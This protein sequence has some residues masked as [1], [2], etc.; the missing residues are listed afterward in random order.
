MDAMLRFPFGSAVKTSEDKATAPR[1]A[2]RQVESMAERLFTL[3]YKVCILADN[4]ELLAKALGKKGVGECRGGGERRRS[5]RCARAAQTRTSRHVRES[6][7]TLGR[8][9]LPDWDA[10][11]GWGA[12]GGES[13]S[14]RL[15]RAQVPT[16]R[17]P[18]PP[19]PPC[20]PLFLLIVGITRWLCQTRTSSTG[21]YAPSRAGQ[22]SRSSPRSMSLVARTFRPM[23]P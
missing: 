22:S 5:C 14:V 17:P 12:R 3:E 21:P 9:R 10:F 1:S 16:R 18:R 2:M 4:L 23:A 7:G 19:R 6:L 15:G 13:A 20:I 11:H 8:N